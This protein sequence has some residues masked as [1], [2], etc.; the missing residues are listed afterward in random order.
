M[1]ARFAWRWWLLSLLLAGLAGWATVHWQAAQ[2]QASQQTHLQLLAHDLALEIRS[3]TS[4][5][6]VLGA[7]QLMG[8]TSASVRGSLLGEA[9]AMARLVEDS[10]HVLRQF[11]AE[12]TYLLS[13]T[14]QVLAYTDN[15]NRQLLLG[16]Q[17]GQRPYWQQ[18]M[19]GEAHIYPAIGIHSH[20]RG[21][22]FAAPVWLPQVPHYPQ[23]VLVIKMGGDFIDGLLRKHGSRAWLLSPD[24][25]IFGSSQPG[26]LFQWLK[27]LA[28]DDLLALRQLHQFDA[29]LGNTP[30]SLLD[31]APAG[32]GELRLGGM[33]YMVA[34]SQLSW[35]DPRG[36][37]KVMVLQDRSQLSPWWHWLPLASLASILVLVASLLL[38][39]RQRWRALQQRHQDEQAAAARQL[40][41]RET[42]FRTL[43][44][45]AS[46]VIMRFTPDG[47]LLY[48]SPALFRQLRQPPR[49]VS[50]C[51]LA[52]LGFSASEAAERE[53]AIA[54]VSQLAQPLRRSFA[55]GLAEHWREWM[56]T[57]ELNAHGQVQSV[58]V[59]S[60]D[61]SEQ[62][63]QQTALA[64]AKQA[65]ELARQQIVDL[66]NTLP[67]AVFQYRQQGEA[68]EF[69]FLSAKTAELFGVSL[70]EIYADP[71]QRWRHVPLAEMQ[72]AR[73]EIR[74]AI[75][76]RRT[77]G[78]QHTVLL[79]GELHHIRT[80]GV[81]ARGA[82]GQDYWNGFFMDI[83]RAVEQAA[84]LEQARHT[85]EAATEAKSRFLANISHE[86]RTPLN[87]VLGLAHLAAK[88][89]DNPRQHDYL[90][91]ISHAGQ[92]LL[93]LIND[94]LDFS[95]I[96]ADRLTLEQIPFSLNDVLAQ[97]ATVTAGR[98][99]EKGLHYWFDLPPTL[100]EQ[101]QGDP[102]RLGQ[103]L[104]NLL[105]NAIKFTAHGE[106][107]LHLQAI[108]EGDACWLSAAVRD[109]GVGMQPEQL[110]RL[111]QPF[112]QADSSTTRQYGGTG[113]GLSIAQ[114]L[115]QLMAGEISVESTPEQ[116]S[117]FRFKVRLSAC[118]APIQPPIQPPTRGHVTLLSRHTGLAQL[119]QRYCLATTFQQIIDDSPIGPSEC[120]LLDILFAPAT[121]LLATARQLRAA[122]PAAELCLLGE[123]AA[124]DWPAWQALGARAI[125]AP[126][127]PAAWRGEAQDITPSAPTLR[128]TPASVLVVEDN[129]IN[130]QIACELLA[131][132]G[133]QACVAGD[134]QAAL[135]QLS[136]APAAH[137]LVLMDIQMP[138]LD[139]YAATRAIR[140]LPALATLPIIAM[141]ANTSAE[142]QAAVR[143]AGMNDYLSKPIDPQQLAQTLSK[144]LRYTAVDIENYEPQSNT[145]E[146]NQWQCLDYPQA[147]RRLANKADTL[148]RL[149]GDFARNYQQ[150]AATLATHIASADW[151]SAQRLAHT[152]KGVAGNL[153]LQ[154]IPTLAAEL[155]NA[156]APAAP[157]PTA[158]EALLAELAKALSSTCTEIQA[159]LPAPTSPTEATAPLLSPAELLN[160]LEIL[161]LW[162]ESNDRRASAAF[163]RLRPSIAAHYP[164]AE[165]AALQAALDDYDF[166][167]LADW[168]AQT[169]ASPT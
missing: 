147:L 131:E 73:S 69:T 105:N 97:V 120:Y 103:V 86:I 42:A 132:L 68:G 55:Y 56:L 123:P 11:G 20:E 88:H 76:E 9:S 164:R 89:S 16:E 135:E 118:A 111:F 144:Y 14:G 71:A 160:E 4:E 117:V 161:Q 108:Q 1:Q 79:A 139:G 137:A 63:A 51:R 64:N 65:A 133:L 66:S 84:A 96:E 110:A 32:A 80:V 134:G 124:E 45:N 112:T 142:D 138:R 19:R 59:T 125:A 119:A 78:V 46:D 62:L 61:I 128:F 3:N 70:Q 145:P 30:P 126:Y 156:C 167:P 58:L 29:L 166:A 143:A 22:Y 159:K 13:G 40:Q 38:Y 43:A 50:S 18:A 5:G 165:L 92:V 115:V 75:A 122:Q 7:A 151:A 67:L 35:P 10:Q 60:R 41:E 74:A 25:L 37:W 101:W 49:E 113:L 168:V 163:A 93:S 136:A 90:N 72:Q 157:Q 154:R 47:R 153:G 121:S 82:D 104:I 81:P 44:E 91:K 36:T 149:L 155:E 162:L 34:E 146:A 106:V 48:A 141:T 107:S 2:Q 158:T 148:N 6:R 152:L 129:T 140:R 17:L 102:L 77:A 100:P 24:G 8:R 12:S 28:A 130:Q 23:G 52:D 98:A 21:L 26:D 53:A 27:P 94:L 87:A 116:G 31:W 15:Q 150:A 39:A 95:K 33:R 109:T 114:R 57:P 169:L 99:Q 83:T 127:L 54:S 85:A